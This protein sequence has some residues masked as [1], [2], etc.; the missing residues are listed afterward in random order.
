MR[1]IFQWY[2]TLISF[3]VI[4]CTLSTPSYVFAST[5]EHHTSLR[6]HPT[7]CKPTKDI[8]PAWWTCTSGPNMPCDYTNYK[9]YTGVTPVLLTSWRGIEVCGPA[10][11]TDRPV[12]FIPNPNG[13][14]ELEFECPELVKRYLLLLYDLPS[15]QADGYQVVDAYTVVYPNLLK[16]ITPD[17]HIFP[18]VGDVLSYGSTNP[19]HTSIVTKVTNENLKTGSA[20]VTVIEQNI[21]G[22]AHGTETMQMSN[23]QMSGMG[24]AV[25]EWMT[26][27]TWTIAH[28]PSLK[29]YVSSLR[30]VSVLSPNDVWAVGSNGSQQAFT[31]HWN[32]QK[33]SF[34]SSPLLSESFLTSVA[35]IS[36]TDVWAVGYYGASGANQAL[37]EH[38]NGQKWSIVSSPNFASDDLNSVIA[39]SS[40]DVWAVGDSCYPDGECQTLT[41]HWDGTQW[42]IV[43]SPNGAIGGINIL[44]GATGTA[45]D[46]VWAAG[47]DYSNSNPS[48]TLIMHWDGTQWTIISSPNVGTESNSISGVAAVSS[49][50]IWVVGNICC[51]QWNTLTMHWDGTQWTVIPSPNV[52][53][54]TRDI[55]NTV[56]VRSTN[57]VW[58]I[59]NYDVPGTINRQTLILHYDGIQWN[60]IPSVNNKLFPQHELWGIA[61]T[62]GSPWE[63]WTVGDN[64]NN[65]THTSQTLVEYYS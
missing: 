14:T 15:V 41:E 43:T 20:S 5:P 51:N 31:E 12:Q 60:V 3:L 22:L 19:G 39:L 7:Q 6:Q 57:D 33:W 54:S 2:V 21:S 44:A 17:M 37:T 58:A 16:K 56:A 4:I 42:T 45:S 26:F 36:S 25:A 30:S 11:T 63:A 47:Y 24:G 1:Q 9:N 46:D 38:W 64:Y 40:T 53:G 48:Q 29:G 8:Q 49:S 61:L 62:L 34:Q 10:P 23:W 59:G 32:G 13:T 50:D 28:T 65:Q 55:L 27:R 18:S 52:N 35:A